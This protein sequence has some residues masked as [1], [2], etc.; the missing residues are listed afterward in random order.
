M[1]VSTDA[2]NDQVSAE[3]HLILCTEREL[4]LLIKDDKWRF[5]RDILTDVHKRA[6]SALRKD[7]MFVPG[8]GYWNMMTFPIVVAGWECTIPI[9]PETVT[10]LECAI[11][12]MR[13]LERILYILITERPRLLALRQ[14]QAAPSTVLTASSSTPAI[15]AISGS[16]TQALFIPAAIAE[17]LK[18]IETLE[19]NMSSPTPQGQSPES[20]QIESIVQWLFA[21]RQ[22]GK[23]ALRTEDKLMSIRRDTFTQPGTADTL[24][25]RHAP[26]PEL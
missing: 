5:K 15:V 3:Q 8:T 17:R 13:R 10:N 25:M 14:A 12:A 1:E 26:V 9:E 7:E 11:K 4:L 21:E 2:P 20:Q 24:L 23:V 16:S 22:S 18:E 6:L 19:E